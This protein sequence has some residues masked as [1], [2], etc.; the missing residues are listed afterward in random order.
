MNNKT[1]VGLVFVSGML[2]TF[3][4][5][6]AG[7]VYANKLIE[8]ENKKRNKTDE[9]IKAEEPENIKDQTLN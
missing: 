5:M 2:V 1:K 8:N 3:G 4:G 7:L 9:N 6:I